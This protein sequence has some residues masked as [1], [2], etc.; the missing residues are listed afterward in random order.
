MILPYKGTTVAVLFLLYFAYV[1]LLVTLKTLRYDTNLAA[2]RL[3]HSCEKKYLSL[4][5]LNYI[6]K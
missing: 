3:H 4:I 1:S 2:K 6:V 5:L